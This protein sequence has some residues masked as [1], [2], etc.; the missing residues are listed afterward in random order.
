MSRRRKSGSIPAPP[1]I[2]KAAKEAEQ[3]FA[4]LFPKGFK[5]KRAKQNNATLKYLARRD[6]GP[7][8][9]KRGAKPPGG[10]KPG[11]AAAWID[12]VCPN[13]EWR[14]MSAKTVEAAIA[15]E[16]DDRNKN[17][18]GPRIKKKP[19]YSAIQ[20]EIKQRKTQRAKTQKT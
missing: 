10:P 19:S 5:P 1:E 11:F 8:P 12:E 20:K 3:F 6:L 7:P 2:A 13:G 17:T 15:T 16:I 9:S 4:K 18:K 14:L